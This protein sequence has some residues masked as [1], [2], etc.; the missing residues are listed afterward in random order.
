M[1]NKTCFKTLREYL[2]GDT[3]S[4]FVIPNYQRGYKWSVRMKNKGELGLS[5]IQGLLDNLIDAYKRACKSGDYFLQGVTVSEFK[6]KGEN[7][8]I[9]IDGQQRTTSLYF[10]LWCLGQE[11]IGAIQIQYDVR[12][13]SQIFLKR[14]KEIRNGE[15]VRQCM[16]RVEDKLSDG[17]KYSDIVKNDE[18]QDVH[19]FFE[20]LSQ[21]NERISA[22]DK[23]KFLQYILDHVSLLYEVVAKP[24]LST[25]RAALPPDAHASHRPRLSLTT[26]FSN[27]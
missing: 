21:I 19:Y 16:S 5:S 2:Y 17:R 14:L 8:I 10:I 22:V 6:N 20:A 25:A 1:A 18:S 4:I 13:G 27:G 15:D 23:V 24:L 3:N 11:N 7:K 9:L 26:P 12:E